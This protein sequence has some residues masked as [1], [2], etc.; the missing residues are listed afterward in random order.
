[1]WCCRKRDKDIEE[2]EEKNDK[3]EKKKTKSEGFLPHWCLYIAWTLCIA[4]SFTSALY[5]LFYSMMWGRE[6]SNQW[7]F[8]MILT[9]SQD[10]LINQP[11]KVLFL[12][13]AYAIFIRKSDEESDVEQGGEDPKK[14]KK[15]STEQFFVFNLEQCSFTVCY[16]CNEPMH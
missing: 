4:A 1:M 11:A 2:N 6:K 9:F 10:T 3:E 14:G 16:D 15:A 13:V 5:T 12:S 8:S 7:F